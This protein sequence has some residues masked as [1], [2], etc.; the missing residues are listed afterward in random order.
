M[1]TIA[2]AGVIVALILIQYGFFLIIY[3][4]D[5]DTYLNN[6]NIIFF[7]ILIFMACKP[8]NVLIN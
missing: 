1:A 2:R 3:V 6:L 7:K 8:W 4:C 5:P